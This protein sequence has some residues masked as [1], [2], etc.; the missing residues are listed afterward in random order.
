MTSCAT[1]SM[2]STFHVG[3]VTPPPAPLE[4]EEEEGRLELEDDAV[5]AGAGALRESSW[6]RAATWWSRSVLGVDMVVVQREKRRGEASG[7]SERGA[8]DAALRVGD[9]GRGK[10]QLEARS[11]VVT[12]LQGPTAVLACSLESRSHLAL[13]RLVLLTA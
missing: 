12:A 2:M 7:R 13:P 11:S 8:S 10:L 4:P 6:V 3:I 1:L 5:E 9:F